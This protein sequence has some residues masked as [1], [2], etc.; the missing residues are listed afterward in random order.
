ML[1]WLRELAGWILLGIGLAMFALVYMWLV[2]KRIIEGF[3]LGV[4]G[5]MVFRAGIGMLKVAVAARA[6]GEVKR[7]MAEAGTIRRK[8]ARVQL[9]RKELPGRTTE[10]V[11]PGP[12]G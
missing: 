11:L 3:L 12:K 2:N 8:P 10:S 5:I 7:D 1:A 9:G 6:M 4:A